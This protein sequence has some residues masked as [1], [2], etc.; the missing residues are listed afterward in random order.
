MAASTHIFVYGLLTFPEVVTAITGRTI[1]AKHAVLPGFRR[2]GLTK[3][4]LATPVPVLLPEEGF[5]QTGQLLLDV[6][7][8][9]V[10]KLD[11]FEDLDS[12]HYEKTAVRVEV[13]G[14]WLSAFCYSAGPGL[15]PY[16]SG[17]WE[18]EQVSAEAIAQLIRQLTA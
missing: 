6:S 7:A 10:E 16:A 3:S 15:A 2:Y 14:E 1:P 17:R 5:R 18:P 8:E 9:E 13:G 12:G 11:F 4:P